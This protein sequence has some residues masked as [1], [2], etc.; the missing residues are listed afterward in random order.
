MVVHTQTYH[1]RYCANTARHFQ[2]FLTSSC[3]TISPSKGAFSSVKQKSKPR[4][5]KPSERSARINPPLIAGKEFILSSSF[6]TKHVQGCN[7]IF[8]K[9]FTTSTQKVKE[10]TMPKRFRHVW[11]GA[12]GDSC[13][14]L[15]NSSIF[16]D[17]GQG[18][19]KRSCGGGGAEL[20]NAVTYQSN[21]SLNSDFM[22]SSFDTLF[23]S[24]SFPTCISFGDQSIPFVSYIQIRS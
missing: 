18:T 14:C 2:Q 22:R 11:G 24:Q 6:Y 21:F 12:N 8:N 13:V 17:G 9:F 16:W 20:R 7:K 4:L 10:G 23:I 15:W 19:N 5:L 3:I 1:F